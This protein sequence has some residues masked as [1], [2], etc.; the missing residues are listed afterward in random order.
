[1][2][3]KFIDFDYL[4]REEKIRL[5]SAVRKPFQADNRALD[6]EGDE[7]LPEYASFLRNDFEHEAAGIHASSTESMVE[8]SINSLRNKYGKLIP[9][10]AVI[11]MTRIL[12][13]LTLNRPLER[14]EILEDISRKHR[15]YRDWRGSGAFVE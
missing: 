11:Y 3:L 1:M 8:T 9:A 10:D 4:C 13:L 14:N 7:I 12:A 15:V 6:R 2:D 5:S